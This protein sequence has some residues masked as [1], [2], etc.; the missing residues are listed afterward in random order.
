MQQVCCSG[1][2]A[3]GVM[4]QVDVDRDICQG[5][6][7]EMSVLH[8]NVEFQFNLHPFVTHRLPGHITSWIAWLVCLGIIMKKEDTRKLKLRWIV[9][10]AGDQGGIMA[11]DR[12]NT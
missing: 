5:R 9:Q 11:R 2:V 10:N 4:Q 3:R 8:G 1:C 12:S 7:P 6:I